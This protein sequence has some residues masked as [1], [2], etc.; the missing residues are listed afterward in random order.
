MPEN[1]SYCGKLDSA[2]MP[3]DGVT[4][5]E[6]AAG[7]GKTYNIQNIVARL[8]VEKNY[9]IETLAVV[10]FTDKAAKELADRMRAMLEL[11]TGVLNNCSTAKPAEQERAKTLLERFT[12]LGI[13]VEEQKYRLEEALRN[14]D[15]CRVSTIHGFCLSLLTEYAFESS[16]TFQLKLEKNTQ[17]VVD[18]LLKDFCR[19]KRYSNI[20]LPG[21]EDLT[22]EKISGKVDTL[23]KRNCIKLVRTRRAFENEEQILQTLSALQKEFATL[24]D[25]AVKI[26]FLLDKLNMIGDLSGNNHIALAINTLNNTDSANCGSV[27]QFYEAVKLFRT[28]IFIDRGKAGSKNKPGYRQI[29]ND[30]VN[31]EKLFTIAE[32][33]CMV[34][35]NDCHVF[36]VENAVKFIKSNL[37]QWKSKNNLLDFDDLLILADQALQDAGFRNFIQKKFNAGIIDEF[38]DTDPL[39]YNIFKAIFIDRQAPQRL[40]MVGDPR[41]AIYFFRGGDMATYLTAREECIAGNGRIYTLSTNF[42]SS[43]KMIDA[44]NRIFEHNDPFFTDEI[45]FEHVEKPSQ[46]KPGI[47]FKGV[48]MEYPLSAQYYGGYKPEDMFE[49]CAEEISK[50]ISCGKFTIPGSQGDHRPIVPGDI[51]VLAADNKHLTTIRQALEKY[52]IPVV[53]ERPGGVWSSS[54]AVEL[55]TFMLAVLENSNTTLVREALLTAIG[56]VELE[57]LDIEAADAGEK[58]LAWRLDFMTLAE[59]WQTKGTAAFMAMTVKLFDLK[60]RLT[61]KSGGDRNLSNYIQLGDLLAAAELANKLSP[62]GVLKFL[63]EKIASS[64][65]DD[66]EMLESDRSAVRL[67]TIHKS[68]GLQFPVVFLPQ[69]SSRYA[70]AK[71]NLKF[72][73][74]GREL[75]CNIDGLDASAL[76]A[77]GMEEMQEIMRLVYVAITRSCYFCR[78]SWCKPYTMERVNP[79]TWLFARQNVQKSDEFRKNF[80]LG[81]IPYSAVELNIPENMVQA[82]LFS[83]FPAQRYLPEINDELL[84]PEKITP[85]RSS[86]SIISYS[87][88]NELGKKDGG[89]P[90]EE[91]TDRDNSD[92]GNDLLFQQ[93]SSEKPEQP[94]EKLS[95]GIWSIPHGAAIG[96]AWHEILE[97]T[98]FTAGVDEFLLKNIMAN[99]G[100]NHPEHLAE[101]MKMFQNL[102]KYQLPCGMK[103]CELTTDRCLTELE[104]LLASPSGFTFS[105]VTN[106]VN[107]YIY[108]EFNTTIAP[109]GF[110]NMHKGFFTGFIDMIFEYNNKLYIVDW[111]SNALGSLKSSFSGDKLKSHML[112]GLYPLQYLCYL[113][114][115]LKYLEHKLGRQVDEKLYNEYV[116]GVYYIFL[117]GMM[118]DEPGGVFSAQ[119]PY[120]TIRALADVI[121][122][123]KGE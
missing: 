27:Q 15:D 73:H 98:D 38:Q 77:A 65:S 17:P 88:L 58:M 118:L 101:S 11:L 115:L 18:K 29:V 76:P 71:K 103:L 28:S 21:W 55:A 60:S 111:K 75:C 91:F 62:R 37:E 85:P 30:Y 86:F 63:Q 2:V 109:Q 46:V 121:T 10:T 80:V 16:M 7:T 72:Y 81:N 53:S 64:D 32:E 59:C 5:I 114:A 36:L 44:F 122:C 8:I 74:C 25:K 116:G 1:K 106:A 119:V 79:M 12:A 104:F 90:L 13:T 35:E 61:V 57:K 50:M 45:N 31:S 3:L 92:E 112:K 9:P 83:E 54:E 108:K 24:P 78:I 69:L 40:F 99:Y 23:R 117:R 26:S 52:N 107:E 97:N 94:E 82:D 66:M 89:N 41:Q 49:L 113:A 105:N 70:L 95:G 84:E 47:R 48:E 56:G 39:Q 110:L 19:S 120:P 6:A 34:V 33:Y 22:P 51:A 43:G 68:K 123:G 14:I 4:L 102:L 67:L 96:N 20:E 87:A 42:R 100:F 93:N